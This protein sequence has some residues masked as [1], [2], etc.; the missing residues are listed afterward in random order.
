MGAGTALAGGFLSC[1]TN[2]VPKS[3]PFQ[4]GRLALCA[5]F[6]GVTER[7][8]FSMIREM[9][10]DPPFGAAAGREQ[11]PQ[12]PQNRDQPPSEP[13]E[14]LDCTQHMPSG[15]DGEAAARGGLS[16]LALGLV[17]S[18]ILKIAA[19]VRALQAQGRKVCNL[20][21][22]D[23]LPKEF[24]IPEIL[25]GAINRAYERRETNYPPS[26][27]MPQAREAVVDF[28]KRALGL[29]YP[30]ESVVICGGA[31][32]AIY[33]TYR[34]IVEPGDRVVYP[35]PSWN[36]NHY[37]N[38][39]GGIS[40]ECPTRPE[41]GFMPTAAVLEPLLRGARLL[42]L[43]S[44][45][46]PTGTVIARDELL[47]ICQLIVDENRRRKG[48]GEKPLYLLYDQVYF[49]LTFGG[50]RHHTPP[51]LLPEM[52]AY[53]IFVDA[54]SKSLCATGLR[55]GWVV[56]PP[57]V[58]SRMRDLL[59]HVGAW[60]PRPE[61]LAAAEVLRDLPG[62]AAFHR[63]MTAK[64]QERLDLLADGLS[65]LQARGLPVRAIPPQG[66]IYLSAQFALHGRTLPETGGTLSSN[67]DIRRYLLD[68]AGMAVV[69][70]QA[71]GMTA[72]TGW[73]RL[74]VGAVSPAEIRETLPRVEAALLALGVAK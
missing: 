64:V 14:P 58:T 42:C 16:Q 60:A 65:A 12:K 52:A 8:N 46:N 38:L 3:S 49:M 19:S 36:N 53:T 22:G 48:T 71:F 62:M 54:I 31:R 55:V 4:Q 13:R 2:R 33:A 39:C 23:F 21:V 63:E 47:R 44:P 43:N 41:E 9:H 61:Q 20:T 74:S 24:P 45:L 67:E 30:V 59:G 25:Q 10:G 18:E 15:A 27:G 73:M 69:P 1:T 72:E 70:F 28:Y 26:D 51:E 35:T 17:G 37:V 32:P 6:A 5:Q 66:A 50:V 68:A 56:A 11:F 34:A 57:Y 29:S 7:K 40:V